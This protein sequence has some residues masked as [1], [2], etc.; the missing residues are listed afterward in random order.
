MI[1]DKFEWKIKMNENEKK[2]SY[3]LYVKLHSKLKLLI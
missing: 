3:N 2:K 1:L